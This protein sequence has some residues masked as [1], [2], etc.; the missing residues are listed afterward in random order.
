MLDPRNYKREIAVTTVALL[1]A[2]AL[3]LTAFIRTS[4][5]GVPAP[6]GQEAGAIHFAESYPT[7]GQTT[8]TL[9]SGLNSNVATQGLTSIRIVG[10]TAAFAIDSFTAGQAGNQLEVLN[11]TA[12]PLTYVNAGA[13]SSSANRIVVGAGASVTQS[14]GYQRADLSYDGTSHHWTMKGAGSPYPT[15]FNAKDFGAQGNGIQVSD[16]AMSASSS[17]LTCSTSQPFKSTDVGK[18]ITV[19]N[20]TNLWN[21]AGV[22]ADGTYQQLVTTITGYTSASQVT[23][24]APCTH[25]GGVTGMNVLFGTDDTTALQ[26]ALAA[27]AASGGTLSIPQGVYCVS[28]NLGASNASGLIV[29]GAGATATMVADLRAHQLVGDVP[30][31]IG[32]A[33][34]GDGYFGLLSFVDSQYVTVRDLSVQGAFPIGQFPLKAAYPPIYAIETTGVD[35]LPARKSVYFGSNYNNGFTKEDTVERVT[36]NWSEDESIYAQGFVDGWN[37]HDCRVINCAGNAYNYNGALASKVTS[38]R[39]EGFLGSSCLQTAGVGFLWAN[40]V[41]IGNNLAYGGCNMLVDS[42]AV[43]ILSSNVIRNYECL[44]CT[45]AIDV[46]GGSYSQ[47]ARIS[48]IDN[49]ITDVRGAYGGSNC[50]NKGGLIYVLDMGGTLLL[51]GNTATNCGEDSGTAQNFISIASQT[52]AGGSRYHPEGNTATNTLGNTLTTLVNL[53]GTVAPNEQV[54]VGTNYAGANVTTQ[55]AVAGPVGI[56]DGNG[57]VQ[58]IAATGTTV[59]GTGTTTALVTANGSVTATLPSAVLAGAGRQIVV[60]NTGTQAGVTTVG[61][62]GGQTISGASTYALSGAYLSTAFKSDGANWYVSGSALPAGT[63]GQFL[64]VNDAGAWNAFSASGD[65]ACSTTNPG[66]CTVQNVTN[67]NSFTISPSATVT[68]TNATPTTLYTE[69]AEALGTTYD[70]IM[71]VIGADTVGDVYRAD[72]HFDYQRTDAGP[73]AVGTAP[74]ATN[75]ITGGTGNTW[76]GVTFAVSGE[77]LVASVTGA[78]STTIVWSLLASKGGGAMKRA[79]LLLLVPALTAGAWYGMAAGRRARA[80]DLCLAQGREI[81]AYR[82]EDARLTPHGVACKC[83]F[84]HAGKKLQEWT[85]DDLGGKPRGVHAYVKD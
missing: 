73:V 51:K 83:V 53:E 52:D 15:V 61:T 26:N 33:S 66:N 48:I 47:A 39:A 57:S 28:A 84:E 80:F 1:V 81:C 58:T 42:N 55:L 20:G 77:S 18:S 3:S 59:V 13:G 32:D 40:N 50:S 11:A 79:L 22:Y 25:A 5:L 70:W 16:G 56:K 36:T 17:V 9:S 65:W 8:V 7:G 49:Q 72:F 37:V 4:P 78:S 74:A 85:G 75:V 43:G 44:G 14:A 31:V 38:N 60:L 29:Q 64:I 63:A 10:P 30:T 24:A 76:G 67:Q 54:L 46:F 35:G 2:V 6:M 71:T 19:T 82:I 23:L 69:P 27:A 62:T 45:P 12:F 68:T 41:C 34:T 21:E